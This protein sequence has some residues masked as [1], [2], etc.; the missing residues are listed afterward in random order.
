MPTPAIPAARDPGYNRTSTPSEQ[1]FRVDL[2]A[3]SSRGVET[4]SLAIESRLKPTGDRIAVTHSFIRT[5][6]QTRAA[7]RL[8]NSVDDSQ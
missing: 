3:D 1:S 7:R 6:H 5:E 8:I 4:A 2:Q